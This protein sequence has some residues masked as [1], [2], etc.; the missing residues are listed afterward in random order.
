MNLKGEKAEIKDNKPQENS[1]LLVTFNGSMFMKNAN[2]MQL[3]NFN[4]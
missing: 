1:E 2:G 4:M 3:F